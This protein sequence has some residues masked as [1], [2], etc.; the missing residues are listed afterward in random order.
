MRQTGIYAAAAL[1]SIDHHLEQLATDHGNASVLAQR[2][3]A[4]RRI[5]LD[6][7]TVQTNIVVFGLADGAPDAATMVSR[8][9][10]Q[11]VLLFAFGP[12]TLRA[13]THLDVTRA[14]CEQAGDVL[15]GIAESQR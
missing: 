4:S 7:A 5:A 8:A 14:H 10:E 9:K 12:R 3:V 15:A 11:G 6:M 1:F 2:L 13:V